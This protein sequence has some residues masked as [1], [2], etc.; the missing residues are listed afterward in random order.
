MIR[1]SRSTVLPLAAAL[2]T[3]IVLTT[4]VARAADTIIASNAALIGSP[5][6][7][8]TSYQAPA[9]ALSACTEYTLRLNYDISGGAP[10]E[11]VVGFQVWNN[12]GD[13][14]LTSSPFGDQIAFGSPPRTY[15]QSV[16]RADN[17]A[18]EEVRFKTSCTDS[19]PDYLF[20]V[21]NYQNGAPLHYTLSLP[22]GEEL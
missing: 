19:T 13:V 15:L 16:R 20:R 10:A 17:P 21:F 8:F 2:V 12:E 4:H 22:G 14:M 5:A 1:P 6:G 9:V 18:I 11:N 3:T 7:A